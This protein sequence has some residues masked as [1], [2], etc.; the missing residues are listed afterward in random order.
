M[1]PDFWN[2][3]YQKTQNPTV[4][5]PKPNPNLRNGTQTR[6]LLPDYITK[7]GLTIKQGPNLMVKPDLMR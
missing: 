6:L 7:L 1:V 4:L 2:F 5:V 3:L